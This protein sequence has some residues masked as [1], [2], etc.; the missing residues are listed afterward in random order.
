MGP[1]AAEHLR[2]QGVRP[3]VLAESVPLEEAA[4]R[5]AQGDAVEKDAGS[6]CCCHSEH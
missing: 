5:V 1:R 3:V 4:L 6:G 2:S